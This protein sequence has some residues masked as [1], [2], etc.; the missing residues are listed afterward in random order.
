MGLA[1]EQAFAL[2]QPGNAGAMAS[3]SP[4]AS[5]AHSR[6]TLVSVRMMCASGS[7]LPSRVSALGTTSSAAMGE[8]P[9]RNTCRCGA[10]AASQAAV[11]SARAVRRPHLYP[12]SKRTMRYTAYARTINRYGGTIT[13]NTPS[14]PGLGEVQFQAGASH[15][16]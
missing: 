8:L 12:L 11:T 1:R 15:A 5:A 9:M 13:V 3:S 10:R 16:F 2:A 14:Y 6:G 7:V 4:S